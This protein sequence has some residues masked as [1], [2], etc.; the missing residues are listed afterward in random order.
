[1]KYLLSLFLLSSCALYQ[2]FQ[3]TKFNWLGDPNH[4][5]Y[6]K[7]ESIAPSPVSTQESSGTAAPHFTEGLRGSWL[8]AK[9][10]D[11][12]HDITV[13]SATTF[14]VEKKSSL[15]LLKTSGK[16]SGVIELTHDTVSYKRGHSIEIKLDEKPLILEVEASKG[17][18][19]KTVRFK[20]VEKLLMQLKDKKNLK[21]ELNINGQ[22]AKVYE[23]NVSGLDD[24]FLN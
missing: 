4:P 22:G 10:Q 17:E 19:S 16:S 3:E 1:M 8:Y 23:F 14:D 7:R 21:V 18:A 11:R 5:S 20:N 15:T 13:Y 12:I 6:K 2:D 9:E 24:L